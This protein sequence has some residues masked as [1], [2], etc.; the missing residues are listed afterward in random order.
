MSEKTKP[1][2]GELI[3]G[4]VTVRDG[5]GV[6]QY[7]GDRLHARLHFTR[8]LKQ[9]NDLTAENAR[10]GKSYDKARDYHDTLETENIKLRGVV[11]KANR[12]V[13]D[14]ILRE[15]NTTVEQIEVD[16]GSPFDMLR[17]MIQERNS[18]REIIDTGGG[19]KCDGCGKYYP[20]S[21]NN[22]GNKCNLCGECAGDKSITRESLDRQAAKQAEQEGGWRIGQTVKTTDNVIQAVPVIADLFDK[23]IKRAEQEGGG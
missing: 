6:V 19:W 15:T 4:I 1:W 10:L 17:K 9:V 12:E 21:K 18:L 8:V 20:R 5:D 13:L 14:L 16:G 7:T 3:D 23:I 11:R 22:Y 2:I